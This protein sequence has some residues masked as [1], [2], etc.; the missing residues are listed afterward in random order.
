MNKDNEPK[1]IFTPTIRAQKLEYIHNNPVEA[2]IVEKA[3]EH[4][5]SGARDYDGR[6]CGLIKN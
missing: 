1:I 2:G 6:Q 4:T 5:Y 3:E